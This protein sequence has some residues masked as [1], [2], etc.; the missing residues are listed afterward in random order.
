MKSK[1]M[2]IVLVLA[3]V[4]VAVGAFYSWHIFFSGA[5]NPPL[6]QSTLTIG[7]N[8]WTVEVASTMREQTLGLSG[9]D[10]LGLEDGMFFIFGQP[11]TQNFWMIGMKFPLDI[12][13]I[14][15]DKVLGFAENDP[16][17]APGTPTTSLKI[18]TSP[19]GTDEV[20]EVNAGTVAKANIK[21]GDLVVLS[22]PN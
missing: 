2:I 10:S 8:S 13:W 5:V 1:S 17:P 21:V 22:P 19:D 11:G 4:L 3:V 12:I 18:Y 16:A 9:R 20:L 14:G 6:K 15:G 7:N